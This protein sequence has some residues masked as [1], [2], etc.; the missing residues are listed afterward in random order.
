MPTTVRAGQGDVLD[1]IVYRHYGTTDRRLVEATLE[2]NP[3]LGDG[4]PVLAM[5]ALVVLPDAGLADTL[6]AATIKLWD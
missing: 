3:G 6:P 5:G 1:L 4:P 2:A